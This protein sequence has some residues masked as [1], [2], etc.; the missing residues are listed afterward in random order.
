MTE[1][2]TVDAS[3][4]SGAV[5]RWVNSSAGQG[6]FTT[7]RALAVTTWNHWLAAATGIPP[8]AAIG[9]PLFDLFPSLRDRGFDDYYQEALDGRVKVLSHSLHRYILPVKR[10]GVPNEEMPQSGRIGPLEGADGIIGTVTLIEDVTE[11]VVSERELRA[12]IARAQQA[13]LTAENASRVKD[14]FLATLSHEIRTPLNAVLGWTQLLRAREQPDAATVRR[15]IEVIDR[16]AS[17]Q[18]TLITDM[19]DIARISAGKVRLDLQDVDLGAVVASAVDGLRPAADAKGV[20]VALDL[21]AEVLHLNAD[22][23]R[24]LQVVWNLVSNAVKFTDRGGS[25]RVA[26]TSGSGLATITVADTGVGMPPEF[27]A[28]AFERFKQADPSAS[29]RHG[30]LGLGLALVRELVQ[31]HGGTVS[32]ESAGVG[33]G[34]TMRVTLPVR[35]ASQAGVAAAGAARAARPRGPLDG[36]HIVVIDDDPDALEITERVVS[37]AGASVETFAS[38]VEALTMLRGPA[39][40]PTLIIADI[41][42]PGADGYVFIRELRK[43]PAEAG[44]AV[45]AIAVTAYVTPEDRKAA[46]AAGFNYHV[47]KPFAPVSLV[48]LIAAAAV[49]AAAAPATGGEP[50][51]N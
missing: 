31:L 9:R 2:Y 12:Q 46:L 10:T 8:A 39:N 22:P 20:S 25:I 13:L 38:S 49:N 33:Q 6:I 30:G 17:A 16:N 7:D 51:S 50:T 1:R 3:T 15:A 28:H 35:D 36:M 23:D 4:L 43:M 5:F 32:A 19:L 11:R 40:P 41:G 24:L 34:A 21:P 18:L 42:M 27:L 14:E 48:Q 44:G 45:P 37:S 47:A 29:R 26:L